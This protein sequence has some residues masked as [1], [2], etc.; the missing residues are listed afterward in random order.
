MSWQGIQGHDEVA[1][2]FRRS[3]ERG[4]LASTYLFVG[5]RGVGKRE[6]A[7]KLAQ[8]LLCPVNA[9]E[10]L[11]PCGRCPSCLQIQAGT[12]PDLLQ[13]AKPEDKAEIPVELLIGKKEKRMQ[14]GL[15]HDIALKPYLGIRR[16]A[17]IDDAD[18]L[19]EEGANALLKTLEEP[20]PRAVMILIGTSADRQLPT[21][22]SRSQLVRFRPLPDAIVAELL[23]AQELVSNPEE[24]RRLASFAGGSLA[25]AVEL[26]DEELWAFRKQLLT[27]LAERNLDSVSFSKQL[28]AFVEAAGK[29]AAYRRA[30]LRQV[31]GFAVEFYR[32]LLGELCGARPS[33]D[34][35]LRQAVQHARNAWAEDPEA[36]I[37]CLERTLEGLAQV[38]RNA[39][40]ST[41]IEAWLDDLARLA[42]SGQAAVTL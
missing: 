35:E 22:R 20:P 14:E 7:V 42:A 24:A 12:H 40:Q 30:R 33:H 37:A 15:C 32:Q 19:N 27:N 10:L 16:V 18:S 1:A 39:N 29:E 31:M 4:R 8:T 38:D 41:L 34:A 13:V 9:P 23:I 3:L 17:I 36:L 25:R 28:A 6:F 2:R 5:P 26:A 11:A 21:I